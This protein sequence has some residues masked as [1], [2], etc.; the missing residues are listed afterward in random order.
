M[1]GKGIFHTHLVV[2]DLQK[3]LRFYTGLFGM[4]QICWLYG[5]DPRV[6]DNTWSR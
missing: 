4:E 3:S 1:V 5:R 6:S 2:S